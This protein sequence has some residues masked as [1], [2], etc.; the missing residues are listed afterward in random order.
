MSKVLIID[1]DPITVAI[2][3]KLFASHGFDVEV[4]VD[5]STGLSAFL[6]ARPDI[7]LLDLGLPGLN[8]FDWLR[9]IREDPALAKFPVV[10]L[11]GV[12]SRAQVMSALSVGASCVLLKSRDEPQRVLDVVTALLEGDGPM[13]W[14]HSTSSGARH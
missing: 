5:G 8:G 3:R 12:S 2:Y 4:A 13:T 9:A 1:D 7:V 6:Q 11:T 14:G 10:V